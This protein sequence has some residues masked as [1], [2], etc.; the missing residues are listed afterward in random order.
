MSVSQTHQ[1]DSAASGSDVI[2]SMLG[3][4]VAAGVVWGVVFGVFAGASYGLEYFKIAVPE[5]VGT[6]LRIGSMVVPVLAA[7]PAAFM[8][9]KFVLRLP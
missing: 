9:Y 3:A 7:I 6:V 1:N 5:I 4:V 2:I 8:A